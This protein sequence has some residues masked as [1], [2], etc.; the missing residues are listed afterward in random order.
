MGT[1]AQGTGNMQVLGP[2]TTVTGAPEPC[3]ALG[4]PK[5]WG[6][7]SSKVARALWPHRYQS[8]MVPGVTQA[9][10][11]QMGT[12]VARPSGP[13]GPGRHWGWVSSL[14]PGRPCCVLSPCPHPHGGCGVGAGSR[15]PGSP[16]GSA[17]GV[18]VCVW[19]H[20]YRRQGHVRGRGGCGKPMSRWSLT[21]EEVALALPA[22]PQ[23]MDKR[24]PDLSLGTQS[25]EGEQPLG[26]GAGDL[27]PATLPPQSQQP[28]AIPTAAPNLPP[29]P[30]AGVPP[31]PPLTWM[32]TSSLHCL[33]V[34]RRSTSTL[35][36][37]LGGTRGCHRGLGTGTHGPPG[38]V[39]TFTAQ[40]F[41]RPQSSTLRMVPKEP[42]ATKPRI[43]GGS[44]G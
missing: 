26:W 33:R 18:R 32:L 11:T 37:T 17:G 19:G 2:H 20:V 24:V 9:L 8:D 13:P 35:G 30:R 34:S 15:A 16:Q 3:W 5:H 43:W 29:P 42:L 7:G 23:A 1:A 27:A 44:R 10:G 4:T 21:D 22:V 40:T 39:P 36:T 25:R 41:S 14:T 38:A 12:K 28:P 31:G 6:H